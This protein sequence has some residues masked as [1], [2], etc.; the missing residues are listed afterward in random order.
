MSFVSF[1]MRLKS[2]FLRRVDGPSAMLALIEIMARTPHGS[3]RG[4]VHFGLRDYLNRSGPQSI[5][6]KRAIDET[7]AALSDLGIDNYRVESITREQAQPGG[8]AVFA[9]SLVSSEGQSELFRVAS[10]E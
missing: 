8:A 10:E 9:V 2:G 6:A 7:N 5:A 4:S 3:W 1:P